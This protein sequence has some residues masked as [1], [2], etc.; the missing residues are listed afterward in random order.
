VLSVSGC[1]SSENNKG[2]TSTEAVTTKQ[3]T[4]NTNETAKIETSQKEADG[5]DTV[6]E[7]ESS[8]KSS[9][10]KESKEELTGKN[11]N[12]NG[13]YQNE[14]ETLSLEAIDETSSEFA[15]SFAGFTGVVRTEEGNVGIYK[16]DSGY[17]LTFTVEGDT[18]TVKSEGTS[19]VL[20]DGMSID[21]VYKLE[22]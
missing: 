6:K 2:E 1:G 4:D 21:G 18:L 17:T 12:W 19:S 13:I 22:Q 10:S 14:V 9:L 20:A 11:V 7:S 15:F 3:T 16:E 8:S 5:T